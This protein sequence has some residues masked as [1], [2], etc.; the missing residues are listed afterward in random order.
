[1]EGTALSGEIARLPPL[2]PGFDSRAWR[3]MQAEFVLVLASSGFLYVLVFLLWSVPPFTKTA[4]SRFDLKQKK[5]HC[6]SPTEQF[7]YSEG[8]PTLKTI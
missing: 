5:V 8:D 7:C 1:M 6:F 2:W 3:N 4:S